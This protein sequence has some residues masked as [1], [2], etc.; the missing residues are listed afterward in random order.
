MQEG[1]TQS[2]GH[3]GEVRLV[4][5]GRYHKV[6]GTV[7]GTVLLGCLLYLFYTW[8]GS[9][10]A[11]GH[12]PVF[13]SSLIFSPWRSHPEDV[14]LFPL[15]RLTSCSCSQDTDSVDVLQISVCL[16]FM[17]NPLT[18]V[19]SKQGDHVWLDFLQHLYSVFHERGPF[20]PLGH[21]V[22]HL[23]SLQNGTE[24]GTFPRE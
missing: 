4:A 21:A 10:C 18:D 2:S 14:L 22:L 17:F 7:Q 11:P 8:H 24:G 20:S 9:M 12:F 15:I 23:C 19:C 16:A 6:Q 3:L 5:F 13:Y 1:N